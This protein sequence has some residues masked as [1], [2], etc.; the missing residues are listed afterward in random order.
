MLNHASADNL[1]KSLDRVEFGSVELTTPDGHTRVFEGRNN[2]PR[3]RVS[4]QDWRA[5]RN[6]A[7]GG[8]I[9]FA[10]DYRKGLW[11]T[12]NLEDLMT[13]ALAN[14]R[15][16]NSY[17]H[18]SRLMQLGA[19]LAYLLRR[20]TKGGSRRNIHA[21][22]DLGNSFYRLW[23]DGGMSYSSAIYKNGDES[24]TQAQN[25]KY[26][27]I[28]DCM[29]ATSG[30]VLEIGCGW[31]AFAERALERGDYA[32]KGITISNEQHE[33]ASGRLNNQAHIALED[34]RD[35]SGKFD[36]IVSI[37]MFEA[38]GERYWPVYFGK[39]RELLNKGG[40]AIVQTITIDEGHFER[41][42]KG[43]D[44]IR[45][46]V[47]PGGMLPSEPRF[48][49]AAASQGL[50]ASNSHFFGQDY[51]RTLEEWLKN[52]DSARDKVLAQGFDAEFIRLWRLYLAACI[53]G[54]R[55]GRTN[56]MQIELTHA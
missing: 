37:E 20:N 29:Q 33:Y 48:E 41:Y 11:E 18:G 19:R 52:F 34:Y 27:R 28:L 16:M 31:G 43:G 54:F 1:F 25:N 46:F 15:A 5:I 3:A 56:V 36:S 51:A 13:F 4:L 21:H 2:G 42:R 26:D 6:L 35:Q 8:D 30:R 55:T 38:V 32:I 14:D 9:A 17:L 49:A 22:Y 47:F 40:R 7:F 24:L 39:I 44:L 12:D 23:L 10:E 53:A 45:S 50:R